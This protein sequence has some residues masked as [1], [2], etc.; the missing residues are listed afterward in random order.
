MVDINTILAGIFGL[1]GAVI[2]AGAT[3]MAQW[4]Y[5]KLQQKVDVTFHVKITHSHCGK[6]RKTWGFRNYDR[7]CSFHVPLWLEVSNTASISKIVR[8]TS[9]YLAKDNMII[10]EMGQLQGVN[11]DSLTKEK[12][13][14]GDEGTYSFS[15]PANSIVRKELEFFVLESKMSDDMKCFDSIW[16]SYFDESDIVHWFCLADVE[17]NWKKGELPQPG[18]WITLKEARSKPEVDYGRF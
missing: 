13:L 9:L 15:I 10:A 6:E 1:I 16:L 11:L 2:G 5:Y 7:G 3:L 12:F 17:G 8:N 4:V 18:S 14:Y